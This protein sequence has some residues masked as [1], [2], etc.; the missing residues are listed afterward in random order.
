MQRP[1]LAALPSARRAWVGAPGQR[2]MAFGLA[3]DL[4]PKPVFDRWIDVAAREHDELFAAIVAGREKRPETRLVLGRIEGAEAGKWDHTLT[5]ASPVRVDWPRGLLWEKPVYSRKTAFGSR[6]E[7]SHNRFG[8]TFVD[9]ESGLV[10]LLLPGAREAACL[11][12]VPLDDGAQLGATAVEGGVLVSVEGAAGRCL[13]VVRPDGSA[14]AWWRSDDASLR[15]LGSPVFDGDAAV[16]PAEAGGAAVL[17]RFALPSLAAAGRVQVAKERGARATVLAA[18]PSGGVLVAAGGQV[19]WVAGADAAPRAETLPDA[20]EP[21]D[22]DA[23]PHVAPPYERPAPAERAAEKKLANLPPQPERSKG[24][25]SFQLIPQKDGPRVWASPVGQELSLDFPFTN[26]GGAC[27]GVYVEVSGPLVARGALVPRSAVVEGEEATFQPAEGAQA[28]RAVM[29]KVRVIAGFVPTRETR[30]LFI[31]NDM[32]RATVRFDVRAAGEEL[33]TVRIGPLVLAASKSG[34][35]AH[36]RRALLGGVAPP[37]PPPP[38]EPPPEVELPPDS[39][40]APLS[41]E[42]SDAPLS[43]E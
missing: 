18:S 8:S 3:D 1:L 24:S 17:L 22:S 25:P 31:P 21:S 28:A 42:S 39:S 10:G 26:H 13:V 23:A 37:P 29:R 27:E 38:P 33:L 5:L 36:T 43:A 15:A 16:V 34:S 14:G 9:P 20:P 6:V 41:A 7:L 2:A 11:L 35:L 4:E 32:L 19:F 40:D 12:R 30:G